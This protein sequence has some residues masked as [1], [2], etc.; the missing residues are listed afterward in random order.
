MSINKN[1]VYEENKMNEN[2][3]NTLKI[4]QLSSPKQE[5]LHKKFFS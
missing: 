3:E 2:E 4:S 5:R 1:F